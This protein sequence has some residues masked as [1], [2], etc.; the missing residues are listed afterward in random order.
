[1]FDII[2]ENG[3]TKRKQAVIGIYAIILNGYICCLLY[4]FSGCQWNDKMNTLNAD[5]QHKSKWK[6]RKLYDVL[7][8]P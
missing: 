7:I 6:W 8:P 4:F 2:W 3:N 5:F 1:M